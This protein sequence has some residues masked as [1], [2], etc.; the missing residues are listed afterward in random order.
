MEISRSKRVVDW[1]AEV[2][3]AEGILGTRIVSYTNYSVFDLN[4]WKCFAAPIGDG[5]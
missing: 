5:L 2:R 1:L 3:D 4:N